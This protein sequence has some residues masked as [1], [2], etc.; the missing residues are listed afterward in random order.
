MLE[1]GVYE[2][3]KSLIKLVKKKDTLSPQEELAAAAFTGGSV[4]FI[5]TPLDLIKTKLTMQA[6]TGGQYSGVI[7]AFM[8]IYSDG[9]VSSLFVGSIAR[10][11]WLLPF[12]TIYLGIYEL[13]KKTILASKVNKVQSK[14]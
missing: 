6:T 3:L 10:I 1:L 4:A 12:T 14:K 11:A 8:S 9:G 5:T 13:S 7:D 2:N